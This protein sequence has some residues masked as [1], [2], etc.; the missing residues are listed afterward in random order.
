MAEL[1]DTEITGSVLLGQS[2]ENTGSAGNLWFD[3]DENIM[4]YSYSL[5]VVAWSTGGNLNTGRSCLAG[6]GTQDATLAFGGQTPAAVTC[7]EEYDGSTETWTN[8]TPATLSATYQNAGAGTQ[9]AALSFGGTPVNTCTQEYNGSTWSAGG[10]LNTGRGLLGGAGTQDAA[11]AFGGSFFSCR[12]ETEEYN[13]S[14]ETWTSNS[15]TNYLSTARGTVAGAGTQNA[16]LAIGGITPSAVSCT[17]EYNGTSWSAGGALI[18]A[19][20]R[21]A[22]AGTQDA[23][24]AMTGGVTCTEEYDGSTWSE[25]TAAPASR[26]YNAGAGTQDAAVTF[27]GTA[28]SNLTLEYSRTFPT[29]VCCL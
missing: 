7:T 25:S 11:L 13:G 8:I 27:G 16:G 21:I 12:S 14:T 17:E 10:N 15:P 22:G 26:T 23:A 6:A 19:R 28:P 4:K 2:A 18:T 9:N 3:S 5:E 29:L 20:G 1:D 24:L